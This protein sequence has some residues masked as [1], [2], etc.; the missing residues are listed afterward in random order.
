MAQ[1]GPAEELRIRNL[2]LECGAK[3][4]EQA[5]AVTS[6][7]ERDEIHDHGAR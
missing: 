6:L 4:V 2:S 5:L 1:T 3:L 7:A